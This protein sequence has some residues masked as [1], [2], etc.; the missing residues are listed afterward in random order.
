MF[1]SVFLLAVFSGRFREESTGQLTY[2]SLQLGSSSFDT[3][4]RFFFRRGG[5]ME[6]NRRSIGA[7]LAC[8]GRNQT[9]LG[10][11]Y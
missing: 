9:E 10:D 11:F 7:Q 4:R 5:A 2:A 6:P 3:G 8:E 1:L